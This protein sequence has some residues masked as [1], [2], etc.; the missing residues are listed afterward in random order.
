MVGKLMTG[1][2]VGSGRRQSRGFA[3]VVVLAVILMMSVLVVG[4]LVMAENETKAAA[5]YMDAA[6]ARLAADSV[7]QIVQSQIRAA[8][9][10]GIG[11]DGKGTHAWASQPG[12][13]RVFDNS[14]DLVNIYKLYS[15]DRMVL[16]D[17]AAL[18]DGQ[19]IPAN[20][21]A[22]PDA[23]VDLNAP[24]SRS[25]STGSN[26]W[27]YPIASPDA[28]GTVA[29][30]TSSKAPGSAAWDDRL[31]MPV[32]WMYVQKNGSMSSDPL[33][34]DPVLRVAY[35][36][37]DESSKI[38]INTASASD[39]SS[40][41]D[42]PRANFRDER[43]KIALGQPAQNEFNRYPGHPATVSLS[44]VLSGSI[45]ALIQATPR[46][47]WGGSENATKNIN[48]VRPPLPGQ[49]RD[50]LYTGPD[51][52]LYNTN[53]IEQLA[54][55]AAS[56]D[57]RRFF[58]TT[59][60][61]SADLNLFGQPR[62]T[63][64]PV[65]AENA[66]DD[67]RAPNAIKR[68]PYD[69]LIAN[70]STIG[71]IGNANAK[72]YCF[73]R[74]DPL[75]QVV[76]WTNFPRNRSLFRYLQ[77]L[78]ASG[79]KI[80][81]FGGSFAEKYDFPEERDQILTEIFDY[82]RCTNLNETYNGQPANFEP[83]TKK[84]DYSGG[85][86]E[87]HV[88][89]KTYA[90]SGYV[91]PIK[92]AD[93]NTRGA[94][95]VPVLSEIGIWLIQTYQDEVRDGA[96]NVTVP[97]QP[98]DPPRVQVG[99]VL[100]TFSPMQGPMT[101]MPLNFSVKVR[102]VTPPR[103]GSRNLFP[104]DQTESFSAG[105]IQT[106]ADGQAFGG[107]DG[108]AW[109]F[110]SH[111]R[112]QAPSFPHSLGRNPPWA[113]KK[114]DAIVLGAGATT[115]DISGGEIEIQFQCAPNNGANL[116]VAQK[117]GAPFQTYRITIPSVTVP[118]PDPK[119][120]TYSATN[121]INT[122]AARNGWFERGIPPSFAPEDVVRGI[123]LRDGDAR[124]VAYCDDVPT[125]FF[126]ENRDYASGARFAHGFRLSSG[127]KTG[128]LGTTNGGYINVTYGQGAS[129]APGANFQTLHGPDI[130][131]R[132][133]S[134]QN[135]GWEGDFDTGIGSLPDGPYL[136]K[137][138]E[139]GLAHNN[140]NAIPPYFYRIWYRGIGLFSPL[141]Q[142]PSAVIF[143]SL[144][145]G[146]KRTLSAYTAASPA[147]AEPWRT[148]NFC[149]NPLS[150]SSHFGLTD[151]PDHLLLD[152]FTMPIVEPYAISEPFSTAGRLNMNYQIVP[153][154]Y[155]QRKTAMMAALGAQQV[156]AIASTLAG[157]YK[158]PTLAGL[159]V[160]FPNEQIRFPLAIDETLKQFDSRFNGQDLFRSASEICGLFLVPQGRTAANVESW[161]A[162]Y[163]L[164]GNNLRERPYATLYPLLTTKSNVF[165]THI[166][167]Q[168]IKRTPTGKIQINGEYR[169]SV[170]FERFL[171]PNDP[172]FS[173]GT[174]DPDA[175][176]LEP[177]FRFRTLS[178]KQFDL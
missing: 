138:D 107:P 99:L 94:G 88:V 102:N 67:P 8:T 40:Y 130:T 3:L 114:S 143:G 13:I 106:Y 126:R 43:G 97:S 131:S 152:L 9:I 153:F 129:A 35:W 74:K 155:I 12:A 18:F 50:R 163:Q 53:R 55:T 104:D 89:S 124:I 46:Y 147:N 69:Q 178:A 61:R 100:E 11:S 21:Q 84:L 25:V 1:I 101:F 166:Q 172:K 58:L 165:T 62:V 136:N 56:I 162:N 28:L 144:P 167:A 19:D 151:P 150:G 57:A 118:V 48:A 60:S 42:I 49:K 171:D 86:S 26:Q 123:E 92:I 83:Y 133:T 115:V 173:A 146:V 31:A 170:T 93:F 103:I 27:I 39:A 2:D 70:A 76:D 78:T 32:R 125:G 33:V 156:V 116:A 112:S 91:L 169:G 36:T 73:V 51:E 139:G 95:R 66:G 87:N 47:E 158:N 168:A 30:F 79:R 176:S 38:N 17:A 160:L 41:A 10:S 5:R 161:W 159:P 23:F 64:W 113:M 34:G 29:G 59:S 119:T 65:Y 164:T 81:G 96:G 44:T 175:I 108:W 54:L 98:F 148:L 110:A 63:I 141:K 37:D 140:S 157:S 127:V 7:L 85:A 80:P 135:E 20:W 14:G 120:F 82:I 128:F 15:S 111:D 121:A 45:A 122:A 22:N 117:A 154:S 6:D 109:L 177:F 52:L 75:S 105:P 4:L 174:A 145:T 90:G 142:S 132:I 77:A 68:T 24:V 137:S 72:H 134:L 71:P 16:V 149:P